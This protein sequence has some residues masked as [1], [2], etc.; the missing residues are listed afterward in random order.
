VI[1]T[2]ESCNHQV[3]TNSLKNVMSSCCTVHQILNKCIDTGA[4]YNLLRSIVSFLREVDSSNDI[5]VLADKALDYANTCQ[6]QFKDALDKVKIMSEDAEKCS[7]ILRAAISE[8]NSKA[9]EYSQTAE[10]QRLGQH[11]L[12]KQSGTMIEVAG[13]TMGV[14][15]GVGVVG[16]AASC[17]FPPVGLFILCTGLLI[18]GVGGTVGLGGKVVGVASTVKGA[19]ASW[20][21][22]YANEARL[23]EQLRATLVDPLNKAKDVFAQYT[24]MVD[25][26][27]NRL[28]EVKKTS[29]SYTIGTVKS[30]LLK[31]ELITLHH[32]LKI[33]SDVWKEQYGLVRGNVESLKMICH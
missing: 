25:F 27:H 5:G 14:G 4:F 1:K 8:K 18:G 13:V 28:T 15:A 22:S 20:N 19:F 7:L 9:Q 12:K 31:A 17:F 23:Q 6:Q 33:S 21:E 24:T 29:E 32:R 2:I 30:P 11:T 3:L 16:V 10:E 26:V